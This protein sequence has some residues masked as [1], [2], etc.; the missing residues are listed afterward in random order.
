MNIYRCGEV[1]GCFVCSVQRA[2]LTKLILPC[3]I[4]GIHLHFVV[5]AITIVMLREV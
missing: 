1:E 3:H 4:V 2:I 5:I